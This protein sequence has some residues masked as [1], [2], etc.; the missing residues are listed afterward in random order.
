MP[1]KIE[2]PNE[3]IELCHTCYNVKDKIVKK[4]WTGTDCF[5]ENSRKVFI[6]QQ[7]A[8]KLK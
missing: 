4:A 3:I 5:P 2:S 7:N 8:D 1:S 6:P